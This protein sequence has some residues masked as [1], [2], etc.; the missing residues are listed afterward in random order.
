[1][2]YRIMFEPKLR[3]TLLQ[4][5]ISTVINT[6]ISKFLLV[7]EE[8]TLIVVIEK[9][10]KFCI[11]VIESL[12]RPA[13]SKLQQRSRRTLNI[14]GVK[15]RPL[16]SVASHIQISV[17]MFARIWWHK[18]NISTYNDASFW[19]SLLHIYMVGL[20][21]ILLIQLSCL[22]SYSYIILS[23]RLIHHMAE[24]YLKLQ[25]FNATEDP[26]FF[27]NSILINQWCNIKIQNRSDALLLFIPS[28]FIVWKECPAYPFFRF[29]KPYFSL[30]KKAPVFIYLGIIHSLDSVWCE[31]IYWKA[32]SQ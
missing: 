22:R 11:L 9:I 20:L 2:I 18:H 4:Q 6:V 23:V 7:N 24:L 3:I 14:H 32:D 10:I 19:T 21:C 12:L 27:L 29:I 8:N 13:P 25:I 26:K 5:Q 28:S 15:W 30:V 17:N 1:M 16:C 31:F